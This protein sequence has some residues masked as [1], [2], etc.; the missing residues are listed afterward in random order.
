MK[1]EI[2]KISSPDDHRGVEKAAKLLDDGAL[3]AFPTET[4]FGIGCKVDKRTFKR[5]NEVKGRNPD[6]RYTLHVGSYEQLNKYIP[7][8]SLKSKKL[9]QNAFPGPVTVVFELDDEA[10]KRPRKNLSKN[11]FELLYTDGTLGIRYPACPVAAAILADTESP[12]VAPSANPAGFPP[13]TTIKEVL[14]YFDGKIECIVEIPDFKLDFKQSSTV[15][16]VG[17]NHIQILR[18]GVVPASRIREWTTIQLLF[19]CTGNTC[20]SPMAEA[21]CRKYFADN[22]GC[23]VDELEHFGYIISSAGI[24]ASEGLPASRHAVEVCCQMQIDLSAHRSRQLTLEDIEQSDMIFTMSRHHRDCIVQSFPSASEKCFL[25]DETFDIM[26][27]IGS[28]LEV[29]QK[30]FQEIR[31]SITKKKE[32]VI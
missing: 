13:A 5:L 19:V 9:V 27:P 4:V 32:F 28:E 21:F 23:Q 8:M 2:L 10:L 11:T 20:R 25:L 3:V 26:D 16:K 7:T 29:Y 30:C 12:V 17:K 18:E 31:N 14:D 24:A 1:T 15:V 22:L 6:K